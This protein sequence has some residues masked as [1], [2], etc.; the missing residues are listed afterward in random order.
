MNTVSNREISNT[1]YEHHLKD[2][3]ATMIQKNWRGFKIRKTFT[4]LPTTGSN[5]RG[6]IFPVGNDPISHLEKKITIKN[7]P[8]ILATGGAQCLVNAINLTMRSDGLPGKK[9]KIFILDH[10]EAIINYW[11]L[12]K[13]SFK[14]SNSI[15]SLLEKLPSYT[16]N[17]ET[18]SITVPFP[19]E[20]TFEDAFQQW[21][22]RKAM[23]YEK[24]KTLHHLYPDLAE[25]SLHP[26]E[27][28][29]FFKQLFQSDHKRFDWVKK[30]VL[31][32]THLIGGDWSGDKAIFQTVKN[33]CNH[34]NYDIFAYASNIEDFLS[35]EEK[36]TFWENLKL[37]EPTMIVKTNTKFLSDRSGYPI[38]TEYLRVVAREKH[39][40]TS[41]SNERKKPVEL[42]VLSVS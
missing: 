4:T 10:A 16:L 17:D 1:L 20:L 24:Q 35:D 28:Y 7:P 34:L 30:T 12:I 42:D 11:K 29:Q 38:S 36:E 26:M 2:Q 13:R 8:A 5:I 32:N 3:A 40:Q 23:P 31:N 21:L 9:P 18:W 37:L 27:H 39:D 6:Y 19:E 41:N 33:I 14:E 15:E 22:C 25:I